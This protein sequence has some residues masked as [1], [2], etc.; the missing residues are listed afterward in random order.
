MDTIHERLHE[1]GQL[2][3]VHPLVLVV[4]EAAELHDAAAGIYFAAATAVYPGVSHAS[5]R[6]VATMPALRI[7]RSSRMLSPGCTKR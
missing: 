2:V 7:R 5:G 3:S 1:V 6:A 4:H